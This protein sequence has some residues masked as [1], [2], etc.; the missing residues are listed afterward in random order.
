MA[1]REP[2]AINPHFWFD[3]QDGKRSDGHRPQATA[4]ISDSTRADD[5]GAAARLSVVRDAAD[6][7]TAATNSP[8]LVGAPSPPPRCQVRGLACAQA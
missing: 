1:V 7:F 8:T 3:E 6:R 4:P 2:D 5:F